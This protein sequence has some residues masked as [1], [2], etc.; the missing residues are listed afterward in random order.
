MFQLKWAGKHT[1]SPFVPT[2]FPHGLVQF[3]L[4]MVDNQIHSELILISSSITI[5]NIPT[6]VLNF[7]QLKYAKEENKV[8]FLN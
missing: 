8:I 6:F 3:N 5:V 7:W 2:R 1:L 4:G